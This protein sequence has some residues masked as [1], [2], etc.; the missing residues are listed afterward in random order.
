MDITRGEITLVYERVTTC[1]MTAD[2]VNADLLRYL[3]NVL[4]GLDADMAFSG[5]WTERVSKNA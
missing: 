5:K 3:E 2:E 4:H 1:G